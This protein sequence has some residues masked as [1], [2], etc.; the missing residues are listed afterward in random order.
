MRLGISISLTGQSGGF[1]PASLFAASEPGVWYDPSDLNT[2]FQDS[3]GT[4]PV[5]AAGDP[6]G[7][8]LDKSKGLTLGPN[9]ALNSNFDTDTVW[10]KGAG[11]TIGSG[12]CSFLGV[13]SGQNVKQGGATIGRWY[14]ATFTV[15][16]CLAGG[17]RVSRGTVVGST[18]GTYTDLILAA[19]VDDFSI[20]AIGTTTGELDNV[21]FQEL[22]GNHAT[23]TTAGSRPLYQIDGNGNP[24]LSFDGVDD[25]LVT[26]TITPGIDKAQVFA[27]VRKLSDAA[28]GMVAEMGTTG[29]NNGIVALANPISSTA[30]L[31]FRSRGSAAATIIQVGIDPAPRTDVLTGVGDIGSDVAQLRRNG[32]LLLSDTTTN[33]GTGNYLAYPLYI[34]RRGGSSLPLNGNLY[35]LIVRFGANLDDGTI[36]ATET[37]MNSNTGA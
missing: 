21:T 28:G 11:I 31:W 23:Q 25:F 13:T 26:S 6:V 19:A 16:S 35:G 4:T 2:L 17:F 32:T 18:P 14:K 7:L 22:A 34:G 27:G 20:R 10:T 29:A 24:Y 1:S 12:V 9:L 15:V 33:Q 36:S 3:A 30:G 8:A 37:W 5:T